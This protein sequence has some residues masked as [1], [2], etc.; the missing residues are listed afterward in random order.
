M[1]VNGVEFPEVAIR[2]FCESHGIARLSLFGSILRPQTGEGGSG[3]RPSSDIDM[4]VGFFPGRAPGLIAISSLQLEL[5]A[6]LG[7]DVD[8]RTPMELSRF[9]RS[10]V[11]RLAVPLHAA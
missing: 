7:R 4:L 11:Q 10:E 1:N 9:F 8:L 6:M 3:F 5:Q 2:Q